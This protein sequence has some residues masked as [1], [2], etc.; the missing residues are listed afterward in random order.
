MKRGGGKTLLASDSSDALNFLFV[1]R[2]HF[3]PHLEGED[4]LKVPEYWDR[5]FSVV[6]HTSSLISFQLPLIFETTLLSQ[7]TD[8]ACNPP[9]NFPLSGEEPVCW[10]LSYRRV[11]TKSI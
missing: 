6:L 7:M 8:V 5:T 11:H 2:G 3:N 10:F 4:L 1:G 9:I